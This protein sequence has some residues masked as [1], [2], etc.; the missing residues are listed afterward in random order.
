M[1]KR[2]QPKMSRFA[3]ASFYVGLFS[4]AEEILAVANLSIIAVIIG[5]VFS[6]AAVVFGILGLRQVKEKRME[7]KWLS[8][9]GIIFGGLG[10]AA[11]PFYFF[12]WMPEVQRIL[13]EKGN[14]LQ[15]Q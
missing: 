14:L 2:I 15:S 4:L 10:I 7:G 6:A 5:A 13:A 3:E 8:I 12:V 11:V 9:T 1:G